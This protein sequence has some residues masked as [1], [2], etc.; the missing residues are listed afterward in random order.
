MFDS[1]HENPEL[2]WND[3]VRSNVKK[4]VSFELNQLNLLQLQN[5]C[6]KWKTVH[7]SSIYMSFAFKIKY[8]LSNKTS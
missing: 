6:T 2:I 3:A 4:V 5:P 7:I 8:V 1:T